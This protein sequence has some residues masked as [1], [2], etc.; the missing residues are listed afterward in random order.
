MTVNNLRMRGN[1]QRVW[2]ELSFLSADF[3]ATLNVMR[4]MK[5]RSLAAI[6][7]QGNPARIHFTKLLWSSITELLIRILP[8]DKALSPHHSWSNHASIFQTTAC[9]DGGWNTRWVYIV[10]L[11]TAWWIGSDP[12]PLATM[13]SPHPSNRSLLAKFKLQN[14]QSAGNG[15]SQIDAE[16]VGYS[17]R[18]LPPKVLRK[19]SKQQHIVRHAAAFTAW[20]T[21]V[22]VCGWTIYFAANH[23]G[24]TADGCG[25]TFETPTQKLFGIN[26][27][28]GGTLTYEQAKGI[29]V[30]W[31]LVLGQ[32]GRVLQAYLLYRVALDALT[33]L[34][35]RSAVPFHLYANV[36]LSWPNSWD[37]FWSIARVVFRKHRWQSALVIAWLLL[38]TTHVFGFVLLWESATGYINPSSQYYQLNNGA[39]ISHTSRNLV[40][41]IYSADLQRIGLHGDLVL[42]SKNDTTYSKLLYCLFHLPLIL[43]LQSPLLTAWL[44]MKN[45]QILLKDAFPEGTFTSP[46]AAAANASLIYHFPSAKQYNNSY[47]PKYPANSKIFA[48]PADPWTRNT[49]AEASESKRGFVPFSSSLPHNETHVKHLSSP[50][51]TFGPQNASTLAAYFTN[52]PNLCY[53]GSVIANDDQLFTPSNLKCIADPGFVWG[54]SKFLLEFGAAVQIVWSTLLYCVWIW[55]GWNGEMHAYGRGGHGRVRAAV[56]VAG[57]VSKEAGEDI[58]GYGDEEIRR[59]MDKVGDVGWVVDDETEEK[60]GE[61]GRLRLRAWRRPEQRAEREC[62]R[63]EEWRKYG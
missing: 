50:L 30:A 26:I 55:A 27:R 22:A 4:L 35:E 14:P 46:D 43:H 25:Y 11:P 54:F 44:D 45:T 33:Y 19:S 24:D 39:L 23:E 13:F 1:Y 28:L 42:K 61:A 59:V 10:E 7:I 47:T 34:M 41:C 48:S 52:A 15:N 21:V 38:S 53:A 36:S 56:D 2:V 5:Q 12:C 29:D 17:S 31:D 57:V 37:G 40:D 51:L 16:A 18:V 49:S 62:V 60:D 8:I 58:G 9:R 20:A 3:K 63:L 32:G 6:T